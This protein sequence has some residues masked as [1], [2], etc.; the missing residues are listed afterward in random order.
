MRPDP[1]TSNDPVILDSYELQRWA[2]R[3]RNAALSA[4]LAKAASAIGRALSERDDVD[5]ELEH[6]PAR[7]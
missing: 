4:W 3:Q 1:V 5:P 7:R 6:G 2:R